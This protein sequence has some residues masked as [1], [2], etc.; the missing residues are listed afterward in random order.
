[1]R[2]I[3]GKLKGRRLKTCRG[4]FLRPTSEKIREAI[5]DIITPFLTDG[6]VLDLFAGTGS[7]GIE[8]LSRG[9]DRAVFIDNNPRIISVLKE[10]IINCQLESQTEVIGLPV[11]KGLKILRSRKETFKLVFLDP[12]Y[13]GNLAGRTLLEIGESKVLTKDGL[14]IVEHS[15]R[16]NIKPFYGNLRLDDQRQYGQTIISFFTH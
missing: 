12:P 2:I 5:F 9:M 7:L 3:G 13:R 15:S 4:N 11:T 6:S 10:N 14:V 16:E 8:T 1:V